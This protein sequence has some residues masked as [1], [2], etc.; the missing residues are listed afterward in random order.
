MALINILGLCFSVY[1]YTWLYP[2]LQANLPI[3]LQSFKVD[4]AVYFL[5]VICASV[6]MCGAA[7]SYTRR[8]NAL[9]GNLGMAACSLIVIFNHFLIEKKWMW[10]GMIYIVNILAYVFFLGLTFM[11]QL[12]TYHYDRRRL[13][14]VAKPAVPNAIVC[15]IFTFTFIQNTVRLII[16]FLNCNAMIQGYSDVM[17]CISCGIH[18]TMAILAEA[19]GPRLATWSFF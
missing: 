5:S 8:I 4:C 17:P 15:G 10:S 19:C 12:S 2:D 9:V 3:G 18:T 13:I 6:A 16:A 14:K 11:G 7:P 1:F